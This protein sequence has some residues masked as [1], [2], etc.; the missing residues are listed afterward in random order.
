MDTQ[1]LHNPLHGTAAAQAS[2]PVLDAAPSR[3]EDAATSRVWKVLAVVCV[4]AAMNLVFFPRAVIDRLSEFEP[5]TVVDAL[6]ATAEAV[7]SLSDRTGIPALVEGLR[8]RFL[9]S[10]AR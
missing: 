1:V 5:G 6:T 9:D 2:I 3:H 4:A 10:I 8:E 7:A